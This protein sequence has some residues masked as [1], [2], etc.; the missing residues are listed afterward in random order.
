M[1]MKIVSLKLADIG[2]GN[3]LLPGGTKPL[4]ETMLTYYQLGLLTFVSVQFHNKGISHQ[5]LR[6]TG[7]LLIW[8]FIQ[9]LKGQWVNGFKLSYPPR[10]H[11]N[12]HPPPCSSP[13]QRSRHCKW[14]SGRQSCLCHCWCHPE[15]LVRL[16]WIHWYWTSRWCSLKTVI[17]YHTITSV[18]NENS[19]EL[20]QYIM[21]LFNQIV[22]LQQITHSP[23]IAFLW[24]AFSTTS[25]KTLI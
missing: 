12:H 11:S 25:V 17:H 16:L 22:T 4:R 24:V 19:Y 13:G 2:S 10:L 23:L 1:D 14:R 15:P 7:K 3:G 20:Q 9:I 21:Y 5:S 8:I 6:L 18:C